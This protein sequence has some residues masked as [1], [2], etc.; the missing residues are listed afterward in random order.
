MKDGHFLRR[1]LNFAPFLNRLST[2]HNC[3]SLIIYAKRI[4]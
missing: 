2:F 1:L 3:I 4:Q